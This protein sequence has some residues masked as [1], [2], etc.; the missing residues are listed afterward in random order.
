MKLPDLAWL[1][2]HPKVQRMLLPV[3]TGLAFVLF[4]FLTFPYETL[5]RRIEVEA[6]AAGADLVI[7]RLGPAGLFG[8]RARDV[9]LKLS[10]APGGEAAPELKFDR[11]DL[12]PDLLPM[13]LRR[14]SFG[15]ALQG[16]GGKASGHAAFSDDPKLPGLKS[17][18]I[19]A[20]DLD[21][22]TFPLRDLAGVDATGKAQLKVDLPTLQPVET[23]GGSVQLA[24]DGA[25]ING[26][27]ALG[28]PVPKS[29]LGRVEGNVTVD[30]G[31]ARLEK[32]SA[33]GGDVEADVDGTIQ[34]RPSLPRSVGE[35][36]VRFRPSDRWLNENP[37]IKGAMGIVQN[38][39]QG[40]GSYVF[41]FT[42][43]LLNMNQ[44]PGR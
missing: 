12:K 27:T 33:R 40:D 26:G 37:L 3:G 15:F 31:V 30:K 7:G 11:A 36:H 19:D 35:L 8:L 10:P 22:A 6:R 43:P 16:Y 28:F 13:I 34:L 41:T 20:R 1:K 38:A 44:R 9:R 5:A 25:G 32:V 17:F 23:A 42:G 39:R 21:L 18:A 4:L 14:T 29:S 2:Q 24:I